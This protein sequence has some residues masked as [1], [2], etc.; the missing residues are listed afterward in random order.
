MSRQRTHINDLL[1]R[2]AI[3][4]VAR[5]YICIVNNER[6][7]LWSAYLYLA[8]ALK[9]LATVR[10]DNDSNSTHVYSA[11]DLHN[12]LAIIGVARP[13]SP[14]IYFCYLAVCYHCDVNQSI[15]CDVIVSLSTRY[16]AIISA[17]W[18]SRLSYVL[19]N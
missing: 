11:R 13:R 17:F 9:Q 3:S 4:L 16:K 19:A 15:S 12:I 8:L 1:W 6:H 2:Q 10:T 7:R 18:L 14:F 5:L